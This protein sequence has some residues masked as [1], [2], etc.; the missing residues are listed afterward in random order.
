MLYITYFTYNL[1]LMIKQIISEQFNLYLNYLYSKN[2]KVWKINNKLT[3]LRDNIPLFEFSDKSL[4]ITVLDKAHLFGNY[5]SSIL[6]SHHS[7]SNLIH[8]NLV[9]AFLNTLPMS[10]PV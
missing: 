8:N 6:T 2:G 9:E 3:K 7:H 5:L 4:D 1:S 10:L